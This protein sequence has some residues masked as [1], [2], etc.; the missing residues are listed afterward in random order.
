MTILKATVLTATNARLNREDSAN[1]IDAKIVNVSMKIT[2]LVEGILE[3][4]DT[5]TIAN[6]AYSG[7]LPTGF[8]AL[9][10]VVDSD[11]YQLEKIDRITDLHAKRRAGVTAG[12]PTH[13]CIHA[14]SIYVH[15]P[16]SGGH[17]LTVFEEYFDTSADSILLPDVA[18]EALIEGVCALLER[19][20]G[21]AGEIPP[22]GLTHEVLFKEEVS[23]LQVLYARR[24]GK[25]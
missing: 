13:Y 10:D 1:A 18:E 11:G 21:V 6:A 20:K 12:D 9:V 15:P 3:K 16:S 23:I 14:N 5:V 7:T 24:K 22:G 2:A 17:T 8:A 4:T 19:D 25:K